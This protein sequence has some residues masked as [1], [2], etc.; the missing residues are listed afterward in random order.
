MQFQVPQN[1]DVP[2][3][4]FW[5]LNFKQLLYIGGGGGFCLFLYFFVGGFYSVIIFGGPV[6]LL[7]IGLSFV[8]YNGQTFVI[9]LQSITRFFTS[10]KMYVWRQDKSEEYTQRTL[11]KQSAQN[12]NPTDTTSDGELVR[13]LRDSLLFDSSASSDSDPDVVI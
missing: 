11:Q 1:L 13:G 5:G 2:D 7:A 10:K 4:I 3:T 12:V 8:S 9:I 6:V